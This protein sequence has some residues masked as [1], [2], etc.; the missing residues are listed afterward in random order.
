MLS[1]SYHS[2]VTNYFHPERAINNTWSVYCFIVRFHADASAPGQSASVYTSTRVEAW[3][4]L[5]SFMRPLAHSPDYGTSAC[6]MIRTRRRRRHVGGHI[7]F[8]SRVGSR[9]PSY[10]PALINRYD[11]WF[12]RRLWILG[13]RYRPVVIVAVSNLIFSLIRYTQLNTA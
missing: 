11:S 2:L 7:V 1:T 9:F 8:D 10:T 12:A 6:R 3:L 5:R 13:P 4:I